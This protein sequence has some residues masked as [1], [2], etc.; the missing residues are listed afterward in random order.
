MR[1]C[2]VQFFHVFPPCLSLLGLR[3]EPRR[4]TLSR[5]MWPTACKGYL[6][7]VTRPSILRRKPKRQGPGSKR[8]G[9]LSPGSKVERITFSHPKPSFL[10][11]G[12]D[13]QPTYSATIGIKKETTATPSEYSDSAKDRRSNLN[14]DSTQYVFTLLP[15]FGALRQNAIRS[16]ID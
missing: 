14:Q 15:C 4:W 10:E 12:K 7:S 8:F 9:C 1:S 6:W 13:D 11:V 3:V 2:R 16:V 5:S